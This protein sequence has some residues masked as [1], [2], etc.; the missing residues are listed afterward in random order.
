[1]TLPY[2][3]NILDVVL[4]SVIALFTLRGALRG[5]LDEVAGLVGI[6]G[7]VWLAGRYYGELGRIFSQY[8]TSQWVYIVAYVLILCM[9]MF[10][11]SMISRALHSFLK[12]AYADWINHL[13][14]AA[15]GGLKGFLIC[16]VMV[17]LLTYFINYADFIKKSR[18]IQPIKETIVVFKQFHPEKYK[19]DIYIYIYRERERER[20]F[21]ETDKP[22]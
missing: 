15:V 11:I 1:M 7:G 9:V 10:V 21:H 17:T 3:L 6:L 14:G 19:L 12:M 8:T 16:A 2:D 5:F 18:M 22:E 4:L 20:D 13:A